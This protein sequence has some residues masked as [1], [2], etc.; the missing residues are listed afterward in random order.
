LA[1]AFCTL[2]LF[3]RGFWNCRPVNDGFGSYLGEK[4]R[5]WFWDG[6]AGKGLYLL[7]HY[8]ALDYLMRLLL[9]V[10]GFPIAA[11]WIS[12]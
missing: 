12:D 8:A 9:R 1:E 2:T 5:H 7:Q 11:I 10:S 4:D 6:L 3:E